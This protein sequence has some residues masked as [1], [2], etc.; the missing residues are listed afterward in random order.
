MTT[1]LV[2][3]RPAYLTCDGGSVSGLARRNG[4][5]WGEGSGRA[6]SHYDVKVLGPLSVTRDGERIDLSSKPALLVALLLANAGD[7]VSVAALI[8]GIWGDDPPA[9][10]RKAVQVKVS[11]ARRILGTDFPLHTERG[12][13]AIGIADLH[14]DTYD[15]VTAVD[16]AATLLDRSP[17]EALDRLD[18]ALALWRGDAYADF[19]DNDALRGEILRLTEQRVRAMRLRFDARLR[20]GDHAAI[21]GDL[22][23]ATT[24]HPYD[25]DFR[26]LH[27]LALYRSGRRTEALRAFD[28]TRNTLIEAGLDPS[29]KLQTVFDDI[30]HQTDRTITAAEPSAQTSRTGNLPQPRSELIG[31]DGDITRL[32]ELLEEKRLVTLTGVGGVGK[33]SL[34]LAAARFSEP[35]FPGG[36][37]LVELGNATADDEVTTT[38]LDAF[39]VKP[40][41]GSSALDA[42]CG[43]LFGLR[44]LM[45]LDNCEQVLDGVVEVANRLLDELPG[46]TILA[47]SREPTGLHGEFQ[48]TVAPLETAGS[49]SDAAQLFRRRAL[50]SG[51]ASEIGD[52]EVITDLCARLDGIPLAIELAAARSRSMSV[53]QLRDR[54][55]DRFRLLKGNRRDND[56]HRTLEATL[57]WSYDLLEGE[58]RT[59]FDRLCVFSGPFD[60]AAAER[61]LSDDHLDELAVSE[62]L[63]SLVNKS[64]LLADRGG[65]RLL[66]TVRDFGQHKGHKQSLEVTRDKHREYYNSWVIEAHD[67]H[68]GADEG[69]WAQRLDA[70]WPNVRAAFAWAIE[71]RDAATALNIIVH[72]GHDFINHRH[73]AEFFGWAITATDLPEAADEPLFPS[74]LGVAASGLAMHGDLDRAGSLAQRATDSLGDEGIDFD[75][76]ARGGLAMVH[77]VSGRLDL[78][79][80]V[81]QERIEA[82]AASHETLRALFLDQL[83]LWQVID[84]RHDDAFAT[85]QQ[86]LALARQTGNPT[87]AAFALAVQGMARA[88]SDPIEALKLYDESLGI[89]DAAA[90]TWIASAARQRTAHTLMDLGRS[91]D[92]LALG[93]E[94][95]WS[96]LRQGDL[97]LVSDSLFACARALAAM[98]NSH[99]AA[100]LFGATVWG[101]PTGLR[102]PRRVALR[103][104]IAAALGEPM[105]ADLIDRGRAMSVPDALM[106]AQSVVDPTPNADSLW[107]AAS[108]A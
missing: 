94:T 88:P 73:A 28:R 63:G 33:T 5:I 97:W 16:E 38:V 35:A 85:A 69:L 2:R 58:E 34:A 53:T 62:H 91:A 93:L 55:G 24:E 10:A 31:R 90:V 20:L 72:L 68:L 87:T 23:A 75:Q 18:A 27:M 39:G 98:Q 79:C 32:D 56:R 77:A 66:E 30:L 17:R 4:R 107:G 71:R 22:D 54:L 95:A 41:R 104:E 36:A 80:E 74:A 61:V 82:G 52:D 81:L 103:A 26:R 64:M 3:M 42:L 40:Q 67:G 57:A 46:I 1:Q 92:A 14:L 19:A 108:R 25:E 29:N 8:D 84:L 37:W 83:A 49:E 102:G 44:L 99:D 101:D 13:Y 9:T 6:V 106:L 21:I 105:A 11:H 50:A 51:W 43:A 45:V 47:T 96:F 48:L 60:L 86:G 76:L 78:A 70:A 59:L 7:T 100:L 89:S 65:F 12:G 15:F